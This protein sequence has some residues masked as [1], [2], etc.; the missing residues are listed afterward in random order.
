[1]AVASAVRIAFEPL[2]YLP[3][4]D[5]VNG[6]FIPV[7]TTSGMVPNDGMD[8]A[9]PIINP[10]RMLKIKNIT[11]TDVYISYNGIQAEDIIISPSGE[12]DDYGSNQS[13]AGGLLELPAGGFIYVMGVGAAPTSGTIYVTVIYADVA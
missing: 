1:M 11:N 7:K 8:I 6:A 10:V 9:T 4:G 12:V 5:F 2:R 3:F 13:F